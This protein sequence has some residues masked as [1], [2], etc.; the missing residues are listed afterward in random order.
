VASLGIELTDE[1]VVT[2]EAP[3]TPRHDF[4]GVSDDAAL[5]RIFG[6]ARHQARAGLKLGLTCEGHPTS[7]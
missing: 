7:S 2:L 1:E 4:Q 6:P 3:Y 5:A